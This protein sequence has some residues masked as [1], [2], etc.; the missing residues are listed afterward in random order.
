MSVFGASHMLIENII[1]R[2]WN[3][4]YKWAYMWFFL[5]FTISFHHTIASAD[6]YSTSYF[7]VLC[8]HTKCLLLLF[9]FLFHSL[10]FTLYTLCFA[11]KFTVFFFWFSSKKCQNLY[12]KQQRLDKYKLLAT[13]SN[14][15]PIEQELEFH[16]GITLCA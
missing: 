12:D 9:F 14:V 6:K 16:L 3:S 8:F 7:T 1:M 11:E 15:T 13:K 4:S 5:A 2:S 10:E